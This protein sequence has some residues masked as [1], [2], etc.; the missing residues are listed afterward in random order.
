MVAA[1]ALLPHPLASP[2]LLAYAL[3]GEGVASGSPHGDNLA[4]CLLGGMVLVRSLDSPDLVPIHV[5]DSIRCVLVHPYLRVETR[6]ARA[7]LPREVPLHTCIEQSANLA[8]L[9]AGC[10]TGD[11]ELI[12][13]SLADILIEPHRA[14]LVPGFRSVQRA[15]L[16]GGAL[17]CSLS[18]AGPSLF[19]WCANDSS[20]EEVRERMGGAFAAEGIGT[21]AWISPVNAPGAGVVETV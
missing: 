12:G 8:G 21:D 1:N 13:R 9:L 19:A 4:A 15:A 20:A 6:A 2:Q 3:V 10:L 18:G 16:E 11:I 7:V 17:G 14:A 5:P